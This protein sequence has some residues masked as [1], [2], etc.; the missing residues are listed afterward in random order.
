META[1][2]SDCDTETSETTEERYV[3]DIVNKRLD[4]VRYTAHVLSLLKNE[5]RNKAFVNIV[6]D[7][8]GN[9]V[10]KLVCCS[11]DTV[12]TL[13]TGT[14]E[15]DFHIRERQ[16]HYHNIGDDLSKCGKQW[17]QID[18]QGRP[19]YKEATQ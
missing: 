14:G 9:K 17:P 13:D 11:D 6:L 10:P 7:R 19:I 4:T 16:D 5:Q 18:R 15:V 1:T 3:E 2:E 8:R 12:L